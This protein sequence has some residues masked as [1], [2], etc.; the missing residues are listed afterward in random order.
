MVYSFMVLILEYAGGEA[1]CV[2]KMQGRPPLTLPCP[3]CFLR[4]TRTVRGD[5]LL[6]LILALA[7]A[8]SL[9]RTHNV[10]LHQPLPNVALTLNL[11][12][13]R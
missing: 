6:A 10:R 3:F 2:A 9:R 13:S 1:N 4:R 12:H 5:L 11:R 8:L 7:L